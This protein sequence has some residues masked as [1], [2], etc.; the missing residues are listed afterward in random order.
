MQMQE[1][2]DFSKW[3]QQAVTSLTLEMICS[4]DWKNVI[5]F[6]ELHSIHGAWACN[7][8]ARR[9]LETVS[10]HRIGAE[11]VSCN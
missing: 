10:I 3:R 4:F 6:C 7:N 2:G 8:D 1:A 5:G 11:R 9:S